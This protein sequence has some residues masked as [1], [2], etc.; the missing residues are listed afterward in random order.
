VHGGGVAVA[1]QEPD[2]VAAAAGGFDRLVRFVLGVE[3]ESQ[4]RTRRV[5][6]VGGL[7][8]QDLDPAVTK[9]LAS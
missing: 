6:E 9:A 5:G 4:R 2:L 7:D 3:H 1:H 8:H